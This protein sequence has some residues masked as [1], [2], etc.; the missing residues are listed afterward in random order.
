M[1]QSLFGQTKVTQDRQEIC[2]FHTSKMFTTVTMKIP[3]WT[4]YLNP[5]TQS[6]TVLDRACVYAISCE[7]QFL[8]SGFTQL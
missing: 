1:V 6:D 3:H 2:I 4:R 8:A 7:F 5:N